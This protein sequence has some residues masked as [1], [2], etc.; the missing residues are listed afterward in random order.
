MSRKW[1]KKMSA[2]MK[3]NPQNAQYAFLSSCRISC[4]YMCAVRCIIQIEKSWNFL[5]SHYSQILRD[6]WR[7]WTF[8]KKFKLHLLLFVLGSE[9]ADWLRKYYLVDFRKVYSAAF[10]HLTKEYIG[11]LFEELKY[12]YLPIIDS[13]KVSI[14]IE[15]RTY[16]HARTYKAKYENSFSCFV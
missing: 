8:K 3:W 5:R 2:L 13:N 12:T 4:I 1:K 9:N 10:D 16:E 14:G 7:R 15:F 6:R 11:T